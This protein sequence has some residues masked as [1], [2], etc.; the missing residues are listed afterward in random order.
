[1][2]ALVTFALALWLGLDAYGDITITTFTHSDIQLEYA[3]K[4]IHI[5]PW[6][7]SDLST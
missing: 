5:D 3:G 7:V 4:V 2:K 6:S 1:M